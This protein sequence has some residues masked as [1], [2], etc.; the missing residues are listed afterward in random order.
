MPAQQP[1]ARTLDAANGRLRARPA[2]PREPTTQTGRASL[3]IAGTRPSFI[4]VPASYKAQKP[5]P[6]VVFLH[7]AGGSAEY[8]LNLLQPLADAAGLIVLAPSSYGRTWD[9]IEGGYG[10]DVALIDE[11]LAHAF[12]R[13]AVDPA[14]LAIGG[15]SDG[16]SYALSLGLTNGDL[17]SHILAL[18]PG[19]MAP[20]R[21][22]G[23]P[24]IY[25]AHGTHDTVLP[26]ERCS[27]RIVRHLKRAGYSVR[28]DEFDG[29]HTVPEAIGLE[30][31][32]WFSGAEDRGSALTV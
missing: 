9:V 15:F 23:A 19:F 31:I 22:V 13:Y 32:R 20:S 18:S 8:G 5:A 4:A 26:I 12:A 3:P 7:G 11:A 27:R 16:A 25:I 10:P 17:F 29:G 28:Y 21:Q 1:T 6:L 2:P 30:A 24:G 14:H